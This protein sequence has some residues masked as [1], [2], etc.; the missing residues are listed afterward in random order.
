MTIVHRLLNSHKYIQQSSVDAAYQFCMD[1]I[2]LLI[3]TDQTPVKLDTNGRKASEI[4][5]WKYC[6][7][8]SRYFT[9]LM[10]FTTCDNFDILIYV[11]SLYIWASCRKQNKPFW[12]HD[13][14][15]FSTLLALCEGNPPVMG[16][17]PHTKGL[18]VQ[19]FNVAL[20]FA[21][22]WSWAN[23]QVADDMRRHDTHVMSLQC[24]WQIWNWKILET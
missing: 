3:Q 9:W 11:I 18:S 22:A 1:S 5:F 15:K 14:E 6:L 2:G 10:M 23:D 12:R 16:G 7:N 8:K 19:G 20:K 24:V 17:F 21:W 13:M 4:C